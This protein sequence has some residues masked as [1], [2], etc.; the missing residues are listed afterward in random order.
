MVH[1]KHTPQR[2]NPWSGLL[3]IPIAYSGSESSSEEAPPPKKPSHI[4][5]S[6]QAAS[7]SQ[8][9]IIIRIPIPIPVLSD[10]IPP[11][12]IPPPTAPIPQQQQLQGRRQQAPPRLPQGAPRRPH[13]WRPGTLA[14]REI[15]HYQKTVELLIPRSSFSR[16]VREIHKNVA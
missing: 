8:P 2:P 11:A 10:P 7:S 6:S 3:G 16:V 14:L 9:P 4:A 13:H 5:S 15:R 12:P 1:V